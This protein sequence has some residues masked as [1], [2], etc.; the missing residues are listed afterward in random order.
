MGI[1]INQTDFTLQED[2]DFKRRLEDNLSVLS[3]LLSDSGFGIG[4]TTLGAEL[5]MYIIDQHGQPL[6]INQEIMDLAEDPL[7][8]LELNRYNLE[9]NLAPCAVVGKP[10]TATEQELLRQ[11]KR[12]NGFAAKMGGRVVPVGILPT[13]TGSDLG[14]HCIT[15]RKRYHALLAQL[16]KRRGSLFQI[17]INGQHPLKLA[18][19][20]IT[21]EGAN[22]SFQIHYRVNPHEYA[23]TFNAIQLATPL[24]IALAANS[25]SLFGHALWHETR[26]PLFKQ[27]IDVRMLD[28]YGWNEP[29]RVNFGRGWI[30]HGALEQFEEAVRMYEPLLPI[31]SGVS[32][33]QQLA[34]GDIPLLSELCLHQGTV[35]LWN[36]PVYDHADG[37]MLRIEMRTL[38]AGPS[39]VDMMANTAFLI[40][41]AEGLKPHINEL[42]PAIPF[43]TAEYNF[44]RAAQHGLGASIVWPQR[45]QHGPKQQPIIQ[46]LNSMLPVAEQGLKNI[47]VD[48]QEISHYLSVIEQRIQRQQSGAIWQ[49]KKLKKLGHRPGNSESLRQ[50][51]EDYIALS[52]QNIPVAQ[53]PLD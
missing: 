26:I 16:L 34:Q 53:W 4:P 47:G 6:H 22:T 24:V 8:T 35:W 18:M 19:S 30:R 39:V 37:G 1:E 25:P 45:G 43:N 32:A 33:R 15:D 2:L 38:P 9:Y 11:L 50:M 52:S 14:L 40:G 29:P 13:L 28:R 7:V 51:L 23:D 27:S 44:Y 10:F 42:L 41:L 36:R 17:D 46:V 20:D 3:T 5:E 31:C 21:L 49:L 12:L 48:Q